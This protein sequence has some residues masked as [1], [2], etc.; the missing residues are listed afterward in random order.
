MW[1]I[2]PVPCVKEDAELNPFRLR[3]AGS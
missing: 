2:G 1:G 3:K